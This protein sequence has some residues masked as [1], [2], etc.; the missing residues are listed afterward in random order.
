MTD[1]E[2]TDLIIENLTV[3]PEQLA[4]LDTLASNLRQSVD[5]AE[6]A[7]KNAETAAIIGAVIDGT[8]EAT[9]KM[10]KDAAVFSSPEVKQARAELATASSLL[11]AAEI[12]AKSMARKFNATLAL[13]ELHANRLRLM[14]SYQP[15][16]KQ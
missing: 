6:V 4:E 8:N 16:K 10:Q 15:S 3:L 5:A 14:A 1:R 7:V 9:R 11:A 2:L 12:D 13:S